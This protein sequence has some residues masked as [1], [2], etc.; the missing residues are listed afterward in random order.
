MSYLRLRSWYGAALVLNSIGMSLVV[1]P[2]EAGLVKGSLV[3]PETTPT[4]PPRVT[5]MSGTAWTG[6]DGAMTALLWS[7]VG[8]AGQFSTPSH[9]YDAAMVF[10]SVDGSA[11]TI[12]AIALPENTVTT[13]Q[14]LMTGTHEWI[15]IAM[16]PQF[17]YSSNWM[18]VTVR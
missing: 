14:Y 13:G 17:D 5:R 11:T 8:V 15:S 7:S 12:V 18:Y 10:D 4:C 1:A 16:I 2:A 6:V 3:V 9:V